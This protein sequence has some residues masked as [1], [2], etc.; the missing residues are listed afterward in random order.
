MG[1]PVIRG[2]LVGSVMAFTITLDPN[3]REGMKAFTHAKYLKITLCSRIDQK[4]EYV[5]MIML[6]CIA[7]DATTTMCL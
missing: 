3:M 4:R 1:G 2:L 7:G 6:W 5:E